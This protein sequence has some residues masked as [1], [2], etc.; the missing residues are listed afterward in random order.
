MGVI[1]QAENQRVKKKRKRA[2]PRW[3]QTQNHRAQDPKRLWSRLNKKTNLRPKRR[4]TSSGKTTMPLTQGRV[5]S[6]VHSGSKKKK[7]HPHHT[8]LKNQGRKLRAA[9]GN[10]RPESSKTPPSKPRET[11]WEK[12]RKKGTNGHHDYGG[13]R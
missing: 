7:R 9:S 5:S 8:P 12:K 6:P 3:R 11:F 4:L 10:E 1:L 13:R 2:T